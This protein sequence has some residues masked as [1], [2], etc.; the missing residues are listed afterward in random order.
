MSSPGPG[1]FRV[2]NPANRSDVP[3]D[4]DQY[5]SPDDAEALRLADEIAHIP[6]VGIRLKPGAVPWSP[7]DSLGCRDRAP[8]IGGFV[9]CPS[10]MDQADIDQVLAAIEDAGGSGEQ[11]R[12]VFT[13]A[14][15]QF[16]T[17]RASA[18]WW[19]AFGESDASE[20]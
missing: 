16:G 4:A 1:D 2:A 6:T 8:L 20:T 9:Y 11:L 15:N 18:V 10:C 3:D 12:N 5:I 19:A 14:V 17:V 7:V 13:R